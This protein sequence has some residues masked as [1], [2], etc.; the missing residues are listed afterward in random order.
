MNQY[1]G[2]KSALTSNGTL[3]LYYLCGLLFFFTGISLLIAAIGALASRS[4]A[5]KE[6]VPF[7]VQ[8]CTWI[9]RSIWLF[10]FLACMLGGGGVYFMGDAFVQLPDTTHIT[11]FEQLWSD[12]TLR[13]AV[14]YTVTFLCLSTFLVLWFIYRMLRGGFKLLQFSTP[15]RSY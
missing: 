15:V 13:F 1:S 9:F 8:H 7:V 2:G 11:N 5:K 12:A 14:Q 4:A 6:G 3:L 10:V